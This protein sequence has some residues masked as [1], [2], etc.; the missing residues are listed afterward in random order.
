MSVAESGNVCGRCGKPDRID[1]VRQPMQTFTYPGQGIDMDEDFEE[2]S[3]SDLRE[4]VRLVQDLDA[5]ADQMVALGVQMAK[6]YS[7]GEVEISV[8]Q[9]QKV[10][11]ANC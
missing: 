1:Y 4:R 11:V 9:T 6:D 7:V 10:L 3:L 2:W 5:L 8:P